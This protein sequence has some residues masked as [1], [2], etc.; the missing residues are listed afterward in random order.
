MQMRLYKISPR[1]FCSGVV[2]A[3]AITRNL[4]AANPGRKIYVVGWLV[5]NAAVIDEMSRLGVTTLDDRETDRLELVSRIDPSE[6]PIVVFSAHGTDP[7]ALSLAQKRGLRVIDVTCVYVT[8]THE[9]ISEQIAAN[10]QVLYI[11]VKNHPETVSALAIHPS[12]TLLEKPEDVDALSYPD[13]GLFVTNQT[14]ISIYEFYGIVKALRKKYRNIE[15][16]NDICNATNERQEAVIAL[17]ETLD[18]LIVVG[19]QRSNNS[20]KLA[21]IGMGKGITS[22]LVTEAKEIDWKWFNGKERVGVTSGAST[23]DNLTNGVF[24]AIVRRLK[25]EIIE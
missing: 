25:P 14:T 5:H 17:A 1:G 12:V 13:E 22:H 8:R 24:D 4:A 2:N 15:F 6:N 16:R 18:L 7:R 20:K 23:P 9:L 10:K 11:G 19:D 3:F 21:E